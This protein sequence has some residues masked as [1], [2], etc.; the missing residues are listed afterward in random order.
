MKTDKEKTYE[1]K[2]TP[3]QKAEIKEL[4]GKEG[5]VIAFKVDELEE[6][7]TPGVNLQ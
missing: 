1:L 5:E 7:I 3:Q 4:T 2:L 6:R